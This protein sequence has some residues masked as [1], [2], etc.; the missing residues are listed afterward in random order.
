V[1]YCSINPTNGAPTSCNNQS[2]NSPN[3]IRFYNGYAYI[4]INSGVQ[5]C[6]INTN[7]SL[8]SCI[9]ASN[10]GIYRL[11]FL[12][13]YAYYTNIGNSVTYCPVN[14]DGT[15]SSTCNIAT[16]LPKQAVGLGFN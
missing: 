9:S 10:N 5:K 12:N 7:G 6:N 15:I 2:F 4:G 3:G 16:T 13:G 11:L 1:V 14:L 8:S